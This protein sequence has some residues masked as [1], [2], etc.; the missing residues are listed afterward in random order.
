MAYS[1][2]AEHVAD[3]ELTTF[4][5]YSNWREKFLLGM[6]C[7]FQLLLMIVYLLLWYILRGE[8]A[9][10]KYMKNL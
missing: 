8:L 10:N 7:K 3:D 1:I 2:L 5:T 6:I 4:F 9:F